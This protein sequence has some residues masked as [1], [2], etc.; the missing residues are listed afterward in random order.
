MRKRVFLKSPVPEN[1]T[2]GSA[3]GGSGNWPSYRD[4]ALSS[5]GDPTSEQRQ[6]LRDVVLDRLKAFNFPVVMDM[7]LGHTAPQLTLPIGCR[8]RIDASSGVVELLESAVL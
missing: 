1:G 8:A 3:R 2:P 5:Q 4:D 6:Q 7:D